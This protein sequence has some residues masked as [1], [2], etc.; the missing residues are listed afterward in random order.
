MQFRN[1]SR[2]GFLRRSAVLSVGMAVAAGARGVSAQTDQSGQQPT[3]ME[4]QGNATT[5]PVNLSSLDTRQGEYAEVNGARIFYQVSGQGD[6]ILLLHGF[7]LSGAMF[8]RNREA[9]SQQ[10]QVI[11]IDHRGY[12]MSEA[13]A[14]PD[15]I[16]TYAEDALAVMDLLGVDQAVIGGHSM[17]GQIA[18]EMYQQAPDRFRGLTLIDTNAYA[19][20]PAEA[21]LE[22]GAAE[23]VDSGG[24]Q[25]I[26]PL[27]LAEFLTGDTRIN[28]PELVNYLTT[29]MEAASTDAA[30][31]GLNAL[32]TRPDYGEALGQVEVPALIL[33]GLTD[34]LYPIE[35]QMRMQEAIPT[36]ELVMIAGAAHA[37]PFEAP[38]R[39]NQAMLDWASRL[40]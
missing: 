33:A 4:Q 14:V 8:D 34:S 35:L 15:D 31:G 1:D 39:A 11:T 17:G 5:Q 13:P 10:F 16:V 3:V 9:L 6:P 7:P 24:V 18:M 23:M 19:A 20:N 21:G 38:E 25:A 32:A 27:F 26:V 22:L 29:I 30:I 37:A 12:G 28:Q 2:R 40:A 36:A